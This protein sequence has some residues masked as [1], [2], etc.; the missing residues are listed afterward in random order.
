M[1]RMN[2][3]NFRRIAISGVFASVLIGLGFLGATP[4]Q[5]PAA[6]PIAAAT[7]D[8]KSLRAR[9]IATRTEIDMLKVEFDAAREAYLSTLLE[10]RKS[11]ESPAGSGNLFDLISSGS[12]R[13]KVEEELTKQKNDAVQKGQ[14]E[15]AIKTMLSHIDNKTK[16]DGDKAEA[17]DAA[18]DIQTFFRGK[19]GATASL[20]RLA[21]LEEDDVKRHLEND[22]GLPPSRE[23][24]RAKSKALHEK[25]FELA[26]LEK[27]YQS[28]K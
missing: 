12:L 18:K 17:E 5:E 6:K 16:L 7:V 11:S 14:V 15:E 24:F 20:R 2:T 22:S 13:E 21:K 10:A 1:P 3:W 27:Q 26:D 9:I 23:A 8:A 4:A 25:E 19:E 28:L